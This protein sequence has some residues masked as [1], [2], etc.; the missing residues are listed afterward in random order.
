M[1]SHRE[2]ARAIPRRRRVLHAVSLGLLLLAVLA[3]GSTQRGTTLVI[4][5]RAFLEFFSGVFTLLA[6]TAVVVAGL[7]ASWRLMP[8]RLR[9]LAQSAHRAAAI[10]SMT[11][12]TAHVLLKE[13]ERHA[14]ILDTVVPAGDL[15]GRSFW[16]S[17]GTIA[18]DMMIFVFGTGVARGRFIGSA[19]GWTWRILHVTAYLCWPVAIVHG[20]KAGRPPKDWVTLSYVVCF[21]LVAVV[22]FARLISSARRRG[23][24]RRDADVTA[25]SVEQSPPET[26]D[27]PDQRF[28]AELKAEA[29]QWARNPQ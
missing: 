22:A 28:W 5:V 16:I 8:I 10:M 3:G 2:L 18:S 23:A 15:H 24:I 9:I 25:R 12:L 21:G 26:Q 17:L 1:T 11:F 14:S 19:R 20:L 6:L 13:M 4:R 29:A 7:A 27:V